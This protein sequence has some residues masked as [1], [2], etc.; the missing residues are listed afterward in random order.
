MNFGVYDNFYAS[1]SVSGDGWG[2]ST[3]ART[4]DYTE[5]TVQVLYGNAGFSGLSYDYE[6]TR[7]F[8]RLCPIPRPPV[9]RRTNSTSA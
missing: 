4:T 9:R 1:G 6:G 3:F 7:F 5:K 2:W 8:C